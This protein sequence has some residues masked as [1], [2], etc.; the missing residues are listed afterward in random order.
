MKV[1]G[2]TV[3]QGQFAA[4]AECSFAHLGDGGAVEIAAGREVLAT[5]FKP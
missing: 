5:P 2:Q 4:L 1:G 3:G